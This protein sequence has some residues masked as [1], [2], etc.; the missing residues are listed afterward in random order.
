MKIWLVTTGSSDVQL[1]TDEHWRVWFRPIQHNYYRLAFEPTQ[2][3]PDDEEPYRIPPRVLGNV[4]N[5]CPEEVW[6]YLT[7]PLLQEFTRT[8]QAEP[9]AQII[10]LLTDQENI[11][12]DK[13]RDNARCPYWQDTCTLLP[14]FKRYFQEHFPTTDLVPIVLRPQAGE[15]G[16]D[17]WDH[18]LDVVRKSLTAVEVAPT[19]VYVSH[20][21][22]TPAISSAVQFT[23]L[24]RFRGDVQFLVSNEYRPEQTRMIPQS[25]YLRGIQLQE[26]KAL[27]DRHDYAGLM[28]LLRS[29]LNPRKTQEKRIRSLLKAAI[30]WNQAKFKN[31]KRLLIPLGIADK[32]DFLWYWMGYESAYLAIVRHQQGNIVEALFHSF[33]AVEGMICNWA[34]E[35]YKKYI[36]YDEKGSPQITEEVQTVLPKYW[37]KMK[38][39]NQNWI[40][41]HDKRNQKRKDKGEVELPLSVGLFSQNLYLLLEAVRPESK[42]NSYMKIVL[43]SAKDERNQQFHRLLG[44]TQDD[45]FKAWKA[46]DVD[47]W[48]TQMQGALEFIARE[49]VHQDM[50][51]LESASLMA[52]VHQELKDAIGQL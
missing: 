39:K 10:L 37:E 38:N 16:L 2:T 45:L 24:A 20:Q 28:S 11:F 32:S 26:A 44:L 4:Y 25:T 5:N 17:D 15:S 46:T 3:I 21:A 51:S 50:H 1:T 7:F 43:Y 30:Q 49:D 31:F 48:Q 35:K 34:E 22:G 13:E 29:S 19:T 23:S 47:S 52:R 40:S 27:L 6:E 14:I 41:D 18:V 12:D 8:L 36:V 9:I 42:N 33:R